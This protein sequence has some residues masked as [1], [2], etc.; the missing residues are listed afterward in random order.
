[1]PAQPQTTKI[2][3]LDVLG[4]QFDKLTEGLG[5]MDKVRLGFDRLL[6]MADTVTMDDLIKEAAEWTGAGLPAAKV[7]SILAQAPVNGGGQAIGDWVK[8]QD[9]DLTQNETMLKQQLEATRHQMGVTALHSL[10]GQ[11]AMQMAQQGQAQ[12]PQPPAP[13][14]MMPAGPGPGAT[15]PLGG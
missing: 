2:S 15:A 5:I 3:P 13:N 4:S 11:H 9:Q 1:M 7:A 6:K 10:G 14:P 12:A 8:K